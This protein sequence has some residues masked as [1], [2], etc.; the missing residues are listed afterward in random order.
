MLPAFT[1]RFWTRDITAM[2]L[3][4]VLTGALSGYIGLLLSFHAGVAAGPAIILV[5]GAL[6]IGSV[7]AGPVGGVLRQLFPKRH[8][9]A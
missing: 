1:A 6:Y 4:A 7:L 9:E 2:I 3:V 5:A 8:L